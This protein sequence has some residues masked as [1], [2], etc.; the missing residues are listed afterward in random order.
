MMRAAAL[1]LMAA[2]TGCQTGAPPRVALAKP[3]CPDVNTPPPSNSSSRKREVAPPPTSKEAPFD[4]ASAKDV[5]LDEE[6]SAEGVSGAFVGYDAGTKQGLVHD[7]E[8]AATGFLPASTFKIPNSIIALETG[9]VEDADYVIPWDGHVRWNPNWN[10]DVSLRVAMRYS[11]V[12]YYQEVARRIGPE[13]MQAWVNHLDYGNRNIEGGIDLFWLKGEIRISAFA[14]VKFLQRFVDRRLPISERTRTLVRE[15]SLFGERGDA[16]VYA[17]TGSTG[18]IEPP[19]KAADWFVGWV[20][21]E[22]GNFYF[23]TLLVE[24]PEGKWAT[25]MLITERVLM[26]LGVL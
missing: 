19:T 8:A 6:F 3:S 14:Q 18:A 20:E 1:G 15:I 10:W 16:Q 21:R 13:R 11:V 22:E 5:D 24:P 12:P 23:A 26:K 17:K 9:V 4:E 2:L 7:R 25:R